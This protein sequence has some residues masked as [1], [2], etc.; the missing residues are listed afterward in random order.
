MCLCD[1]EFVNSLSAKIEK[2]FE[3]DELTQ[4][5]LESY[6]RDKESYIPDSDQ[7]SVSDIGEG[8]LDL[9]DVTPP[10]PGE[11]VNMDHCSVEQRKIIE[12]L[13]VAYE[14]SFA[15]SRYDVGSY[16]GFVASIDVTPDS[17][18]IEKERPMKIDAKRCLRPIV[19]ELV[20]H[21]ILKFAD[22]QDRFLANSHGVAKPQSE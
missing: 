18:H 5:E 19:D 17:S 14:D 4:E 11:K 22:T 3:D 15:K 6:R 13:M 2:H 1:K 8:K 9:M 21:G 16:T 10:D 20:R 7:I 12:D